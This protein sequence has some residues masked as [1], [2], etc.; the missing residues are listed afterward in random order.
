[1]VV[2]IF[3]YFNAIFDNIKNVN[4]VSDSFSFFSFIICKDGK[5]CMLW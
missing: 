3:V 2:F 1:M 5:V 4:S